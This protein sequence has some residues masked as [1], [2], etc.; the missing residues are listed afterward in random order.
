[1]NS[2][3]HV[4]RKITLADFKKNF[5]SSNNKS[6][7]LHYLKHKSRAGISNLGNTCYMNASLQALLCTIKDEHLNSLKGELAIELR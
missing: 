6:Q 1:M 3:Y 7:S 4:E 5:I 2:T